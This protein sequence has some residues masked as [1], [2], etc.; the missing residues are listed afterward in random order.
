MPASEP[1][2]RN[3]RIETV[4]SDDRFHR[5]AR[6]PADGARGRPDVNFHPRGRRL[7]PR[8]RLFR[9]RSSWREPPTLMLDTSAMPSGSAR[10]RSC[11]RRRQRTGEGIARHFAAC[12]TTPGRRRSRL[13]AYQRAL[14]WSPEPPF[15][16]VRAS[17]VRPA[18]I[19]QIRQKRLK[20]EVHH[21]RRSDL[22][23]SSRRHSSRLAP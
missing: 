14:G 16:S 10:S 1:K 21:W 11:S 18:R 19:D 2:T 12:G 3:G 22:Q 9:L 8:T 5:A 17:K 20:G 15:P 13:Q 7:R 4:R 23:C 6:R